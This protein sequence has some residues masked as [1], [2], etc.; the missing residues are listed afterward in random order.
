MTGRGEAELREVTDHGRS[1]GHQ[2]VQQPWKEL[3]ENLRPSW[4][5]Q[6]GVSAL[7]DAPPI[8][9]NRWERVAFDDRDPSVRVSQHAGGE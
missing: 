3:V 9:S 5:Q 6:V 7:G 2:V 1:T 8:L 4:H